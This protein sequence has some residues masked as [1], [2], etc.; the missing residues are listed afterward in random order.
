MKYF[1]NWCFILIL[2]NDLGS[3][4][5][6]PK[7]HKRDTKTENTS[8][9]WGLGSQDREELQEALQLLNMGRQSLSLP[10][11][12]TRLLMQLVDASN[13]TDR[14]D[15]IQQFVEEPFDNP[16]STNEKQYMALSG[17]EGRVNLNNYSVVTPSPEETSSI[18]NGDIE[19]VFKMVV[20]KKVPGSKDNAV[21]KITIVETNQIKPVSSVESMELK[22]KKR[23]WPRRNSFYAPLARQKR[24]KDDPFVRFL[25]GDFSKHNVDEMF[26]DQVGHGGHTV[27]IRDLFNGTGFSE[28]SNRLGKS[29]FGDTDF[30]KGLNTS[31]K[32]T[33]L[34]WMRP[35]HRWESSQTNPKRSQVF[36]EVKDTNNHRNSLSN[37]T[38]WWK[39]KPKHKSYL[40]EGNKYFDE[41]VDDYVYK[42]GAYQ[43][44]IPSVSVAESLSFPR[45]VEF[46]TSHSK[47][48]NI[49]EED[50]MVNSKPNVFS[51]SPMTASSNNTSKNETAENSF[52]A[53]KA[54]KNGY[55]L[56]NSHR[57]ITETTST[58][59]LQPTFIVFIV[60]LCIAIIML[61]Y[62]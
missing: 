10:T 16:S 57:N 49:L 7:L 9:Q 11:E 18:Q 60:L 4:A 62:R 17:E 14:S 28:K 26:G 38:D 6:P 50:S 43:H 23:V 8:A 40:G 48:S 1:L 56:E 45:T 3:S 32:K 47:R 20:R 30:D 5:H 15:Q 24:T 35:S 42:T 19:D 31:F 39:Y 21:H 29:K 53:A 33:Y 36:Y 59:I 12:D 13:S 54:D 51:H 61:A 46:E 58:N 41:D 25:R 37:P 34:P 2:L 22:R 52:V 27:K 55:S 44:S